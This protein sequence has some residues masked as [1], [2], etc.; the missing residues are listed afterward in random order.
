VTVPPA[1]PEFSRPVDA[2]R[3][4]GREATHR[5]AAIATECGALAK[6]FGLVTLDR[7]EAEV[8][9]TLG[10]AGVVRLD[11]SFAADLV[12]ECVVTLE[13]VPSHVAEEFVLLFA[14]SRDQRTVVLDSDDET[15]E[16]LAD[17]RIDIGE[18]VA[19]QLSLALDPYPRAPGASL[20]PRG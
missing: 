20:D 5:I 9:L 10:A 11:A 2:P 6:R 1:Q 19:Q 15:V 8:R 7:L 13:P 12:Q 17:G 3:A 14:A 16:P 4:P 18:A